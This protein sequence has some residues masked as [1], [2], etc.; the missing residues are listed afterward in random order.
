MSSCLSIRSI[1]SL[2]A[3]LTVWQLGPTVARACTPIACSDAAIFPTGGELPLNQLSLRFRPAR[4]V[5]VALDAG[6]VVPHLYRVENQNNTEVPLTM[7]TLANGDILLEPATPPAVGS[8]LVFAADNPCHPERSLSANFVVTAATPEPTTMDMGKLQVALGRGSVSVP[9]SGGS[10][11]LPVDS[12]YADLSVMFSAAALPLASVIEQEVWVDGV[13][14]PGSVKQVYATCLPFEDA[15]ATANLDVGR[16]RVQLR[17]T[18]LDGSTLKTDEVEIELRCVGTTRTLDGGIVILPGDSSDAGPAKDDAGG[19]P[20]AD[21]GPIMARDAA[22]GGSV[23]A[24]SSTV[25]PPCCK[26]TPE[27]E[28]DSD[29]CSLSPRGRSPGWSSG[30]LLT[31]GVLLLSRRRRARLRSVIS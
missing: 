27:N 31:L 11:A 13:R 4:A 23:D 3:G 8:K 18:L 30:S 28:D 20:I 10:C 24:D 21:A 22:L 19:Q 25:T 7:T 9:S 12:A 29:G 15:W 5:R 6:V 14:H 1:M 16:H 2:I 17:G 26:T